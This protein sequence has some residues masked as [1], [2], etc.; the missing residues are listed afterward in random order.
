MIVYS[1][2]TGNTKMIADAIK[3]VLD[4]D[5]C[6][7]CG[8]PDGITTQEADVIFVGFWVFRGSCIEEIEKY[9]KTLEN[10][11]VFLFGTAGF[12]GSESYFETILANVKQYLS[13]SNNV[14][15]SFLC[16]GKMPSSVLERYQVMLE[17]QPGNKNA[18][19]M[20]S[21]YHSAL[22]HPDMHDVEA[23]KVVVKGILNETLK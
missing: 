23:V 3:D 22:L 17:E 6:V 21:N 18:Q 20:I 4:E 12:G 15:G 19:N 10:K 5:S 14:I 11:K 1:S 13:E 9:L 16:Q 7:Y 8:K 2:I